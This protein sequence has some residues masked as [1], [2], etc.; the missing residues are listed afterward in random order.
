MIDNRVIGDI[1][2]AKG[3]EKEKVVNRSSGEKK[4]W[5]AIV[6]PSPCFMTE[7]GVLMSSVQ[8]KHQIVILFRSGFYFEGL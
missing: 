3:E 7:D 2:S 8:E 1:W 6:S 5:T 4:P